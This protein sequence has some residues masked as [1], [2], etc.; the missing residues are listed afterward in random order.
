MAAIRQQRLEPLPT[1]DDDVSG[2]HPVSLPPIV[3]DVAIGTWHAV[4]QGEPAPI[5]AA[6]FVVEGRGRRAFPRTYYLGTR[7]ATGVIPASGWDTDMT[8]D[9]LP[10]AV[11]EKC[12]EWLDAREL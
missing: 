10:P 2:I 5:Y 3:V 1:D 11:I 12:R 6:P 9:G 8:A 4:P 7:F